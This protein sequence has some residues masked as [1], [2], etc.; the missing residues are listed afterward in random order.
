MIAMG[1]SCGIPNWPH[2]KEPK[3]HRSANRDYQYVSFAGILEASDT[4]AILR[5]WSHD[6]AN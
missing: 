1:K 5:I 4:M 2:S 6:V 3:Q